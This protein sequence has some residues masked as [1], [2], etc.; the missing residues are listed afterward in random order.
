MRSRTLLSL[1]LLT[2]CA[3]ALMAA[4][5][6]ALSDVFLLLRGPSLLLGL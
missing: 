5:G 4:C 2:L 3:A 6:N 1:L